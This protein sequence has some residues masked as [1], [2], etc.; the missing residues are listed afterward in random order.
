M[1][2]LSL[3]DEYTR[4]CYELYVDRNIGAQKLCS[5]LYTAIMTHGVP[6][7]IRSDNGPEFV[8]KILQKWLKEE[9]IKTLYIDPGSPWQNGYVESFHDKFRREC[10]NREIFYTLSEARFIINAWRYKFNVVRPHRSLKMLTPQEYAQQECTMALGP[11]DPSYTPASGLRSTGILT[12][13]IL[14]ALNPVKILT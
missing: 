5:I 12:S 9:N 14:D 8:A 11:Q 4:E 2:I 6:E 7:H 10:L 13:R 3:V 1:R